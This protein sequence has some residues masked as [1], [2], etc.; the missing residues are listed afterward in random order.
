MK[1]VA[2]MAAVGILMAYITNTN[3]QYFT[4]ESLPLNLSNALSLS[5][6]RPGQEMESRGVVPH[7][8]V[9]LIPGVLSSGLELW[10]GHK[11]ALSQLA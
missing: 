1:W 2:A 11:F 7:Y 6:P 8:P 10:K 3:N 5:I 9:L 4:T